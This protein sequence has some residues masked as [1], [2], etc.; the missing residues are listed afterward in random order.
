MAA[1]VQVVVT[2]FVLAL[3]ILAAAAL[4][5]ASAG[6]SGTARAQQ[7]RAEVLVQLDAP[8][9]A[10]ARTNAAAARL[11]RQQRTFVEAL[12]AAIGEEGRVPT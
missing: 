3:S 1:G 6:A 7:S 2:R 12:D 11:E 9:L 5:G 10:Y 8:P 4:L